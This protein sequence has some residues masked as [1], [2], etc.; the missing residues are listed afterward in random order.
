MS[1]KIPADWYLR[2]CVNPC[3]WA[4]TGLNGLL[5][6]NGI[7]QKW[8]AVSSEI[9]LY[10]LLHLWLSSF[11]CF[12]VLWLSHS[13][14]TSYLELLLGYVHR[15]G[16]WVLSLIACEVSNLINSHLTDFGTWSFPRGLG[17]VHS[18][19]WHFGILWKIPI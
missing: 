10:R 12:H 13:G 15:E 4:W 11:A 6:T 8:R 9:R 19:S 16:N 14:D 18:P 3:P 17:D 7:W 1:W 5:T 2:V